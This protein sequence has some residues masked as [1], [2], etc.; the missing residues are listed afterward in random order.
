MRPVLFVYDL[1]AYLIPG[2]GML[3][4]TFWFFVGFLAVVFPVEL[5][6]IFALLGF[7]AL[8][9]F[10]GHLI[11]AA[12][13]SWEQW[14]KKR[15]QMFY[16]ELFLNEEDFRYTKQFK[17]ALKKSIQ[18]FFGLNPD[19]RGTDAT[20]RTRR[21]EVFHL[22]YFF[23][24]Q[25]GEGHNAEVFQKTYVLLRG[26]VW[27][28]LAAVLTA[29]VVGGKQAVLLFNLDSGIILP[30]DPFYYYDQLQFILAAGFFALSLPALLLLAARVAEF[31]KK[32]I[33]AVYMNFYALHR[34]PRE[35]VA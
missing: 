32:F 16:M 21:Q 4:L 17:T 22:C 11:Q 23:V 14:Y 29:L 13:L 33:D 5:E 18:D 12:A 30:E 2:A 7:F 35:P 6:G 28:L 31:E 8:A 27:V 26:L 19:V 25:N 10:L 9:F 24:L 15:R 20:R 1:L 34:R 3:L